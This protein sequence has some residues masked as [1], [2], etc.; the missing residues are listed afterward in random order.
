M[1][2][3]SFCK[4]MRQF[5]NPRMGLQAEINLSEMSNREFSY[6]IDWMAS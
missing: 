5:P 2:L 6:E 1:Q 4:H 3:P